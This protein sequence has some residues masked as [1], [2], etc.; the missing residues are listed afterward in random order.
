MLQL[1]Y[2]YRSFIPSYWPT[3]EVV[4]GLPLDLVCEDVADLIYDTFTTDSG[5]LQIDGDGS[6]QPC[7]AYD[8]GQLVE[9]FSLSTCERT[10]NV[11]NS[12]PI[13]TN[14]PYNGETG[15]GIR[16][17]P[18]F[19]NGKAL[20]ADKFLYWGNR[21]YWHA[22]S[23]GASDFF[24]ALRLLYN[25]MLCG[26]VSLGAFALPARTLVHELV[27]YNGFGAHCTYYCCQAGLAGTWYAR[28]RAFLGLPAVDYYASGGLVDT[29]FSVTTSSYSSTCETST[30]S[31]FA[32][33]LEFTDLGNGGD[34]TAY[35]VTS[36]TY[37]TNCQP[38]AAD[39]NF[40]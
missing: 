23:G 1:I 35:E 37:P 30:G 28:T 17:C 26:R 13:G 39:V 40:P 36:A 33:N 5:F 4:T 9:R 27:H 34:S 11:Y 10:F 14:I 31:A 20:V 7:P 12:W 22:M 3:S 32:I 24:E 2:T 29:S 15:G 8:D 6:G 38:P 21:A 18:S 25:A 16:I 19:I